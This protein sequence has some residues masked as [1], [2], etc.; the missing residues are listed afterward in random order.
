MEKRCEVGSEGAKERRR[1][2]AQ[3]VGDAADSEGGAEEEE[4]CLGVF[5]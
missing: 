1:N 2:G 3:E 5:K 4:R